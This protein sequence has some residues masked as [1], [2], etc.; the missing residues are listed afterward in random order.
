MARYNEQNIIF[1]HLPKNG[2]N[3]LHGILDILYSKENTFSIKVVDNTKLN[4]SEFKELPEKERAK[5]KLLKGHMYFGLHKYLVGPS[6]Y[7]TFLRKPEDRIVSFYHYAKSRPQHRLYNQIKDNNWSLKEFVAN[8]I[9]EDVHNAQIRWISGLKG[10]SEQKMLDKAKKN[11]DQHFS[12]VGLQEQFDI[13]LIILSKLYG[14]GLPYYKYLNKGTHH[15]K[16]K[17]IDLETKKIIT[18]KN[19]GDEQLYSYVEKL[20]LEYQTKIKGLS[21]QLKLLWLSNKLYSNPF[22]KIILQ[23]VVNINSSK[24]T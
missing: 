10:A 7:F 16:K 3:T 23:R 22:G 15:N 12:F 24:D 14:W 19:Y 11:I 18:A 2:G 17:S 20:F 9:D 5:I 13:S 8:S 1:L 4:I 21:F 6:D